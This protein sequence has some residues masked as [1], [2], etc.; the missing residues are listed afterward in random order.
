MMSSLWST[1]RHQRCCAHR[2]RRDDQQLYRFF[3]VNSGPCTLAEGGRCVGRPGGYGDGENCA[4]TVAGAGFGRGPCPGRGPCRRLGP[5]PVFNTESSFD[6]VTIM[7][8]GNEHGGTD[9]PVGVMLLAGQ[10]LSWHSD[11]SV[12]ASGWQICFA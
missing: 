4:I 9:C 10:T 1:V 2:R 8:D 3:V 11:S 6:I 12:Q 5:C 7:P